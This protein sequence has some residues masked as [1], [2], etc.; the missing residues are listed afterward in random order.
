[1]G[2][3]VGNLH[4]L[5]DKKSYHKSNKVR[6]SNGRDQGR[7]GGDVRHHNY[8]QRATRRRSLFGELSAPSAQTLVADTNLKRIEERNRSRILVRSISTLPGSPRSPRAHTGCYIKSCKTQAT[9]SSLP[10]RSSG[11]KLIFL[12]WGT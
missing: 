10:H 12:T 6:S 8:L 9:T 1:M 2:I 7:K 4:F 3:H 11:Q 5:N